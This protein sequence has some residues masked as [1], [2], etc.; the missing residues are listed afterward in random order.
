VD[1]AAWLRELGLERYEQAFRESGVD[2]DILADLTEA[3]LEELGISLRDRKK[4]LN[5]IA[6]LSPEECS[7]ALEPT[8]S[9]LEAQRPGELVRFQPERRQ[10]T[11][12]FCD[13]VRSTVAGL[14]PEDMGGAIHAY[15]QCCRNVIGRWEGHIAKCTD[16]VVLVCFGWPRADEGDAERAVHAGLELVAAVGQLRVYG[17]PLAARVG[18][19]TGLVMIGDLIRQGE[20]N[21]GALVGDTPDLAAH[22]H[23]LAEPG[24]I[25]VADG[26]RNL[27]GGLFEYRDLGMQ[28]LKGFA[29]PLRCW[30]VVAES[31]AEGRFEALHGARLTPL[32]G[33]EEEI[34]LLLRCWREARDGEGR[35]VLLAGEPGIGKSRIVRE[36][37]ARLE[38]EPHARRLYQCSPYHTASPLHPLIEQLERRR[39]LRAD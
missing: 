38:N 7:E 13:L 27:L 11:V 34:A 18:I 2:T 17:V 20:A 31:T 8:A 10:L 39:R 29:E 3:D 21:E 33:R 6:A 1:I 5:A 4:F 12:L 14:D 16:D 9:H 36:V 37:R 24:S 25:V 22:V 32:V 19:A 30:R 28:R 23:T 15:Q 26:T 35:V